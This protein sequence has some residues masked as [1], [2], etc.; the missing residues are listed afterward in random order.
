M[1]RYLQLEETERLV[2]TALIHSYYHLSSNG[3][4]LAYLFHHRRYRM[5]IAD[6]LQFFWQLGQPS[7]TYGLLRQIISTLTRYPFIRYC[8][9]FE[10]NMMGLARSSQFEF[11]NFEVLRRELGPVTWSSRHILICYA[12]C[13][14]RKRED[15]YLPI[16]KTIALSIHLQHHIFKQAIL[17]KYY[18][19]ILTRKLLGSTNKRKR[20]SLFLRHMRWIGPS[21]LKKSM[22][23]IGFVMEKIKIYQVKKGVFE[24]FFRAKLVRYLIYGDLDWNESMQKVMIL[25]CD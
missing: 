24:R 11:F 22:K 12:Y 7:R 18:S 25:L 3:L 21:L 4:M 17:E 2:E 20:Y 1:Q 9:L 6:T 16:L 13:L 19:V 10:E 15:N 8:F 14:F 5:M 23:F